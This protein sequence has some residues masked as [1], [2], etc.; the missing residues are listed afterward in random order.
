M[1]DTRLRGAPLDTLDQIRA[2]L[3]RV[4]PEQLGAMGSQC[5]GSA[6][7]GLSGDPA[8]LGVE[9]LLPPGT[10]LVAP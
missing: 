6:V 1:A 5:Q 7:L 3:M 2:A 9:A 10:Q 4:G 8:V